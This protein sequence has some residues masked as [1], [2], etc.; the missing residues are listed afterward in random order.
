[1]D[2]ARGG[3]GPEEPEEDDVHLRRGDREPAVVALQRRLNELAKP[4]GLSLVRQDGFFGPNTE[5]SC[6]EIVFLLGLSE[7]DHPPDGI[8][9]GMRRLLDDPSARGEAQLARAERRQRFQ[10]RRLT[11]DDLIQGVQVLELIGGWDEWVYR[12]SE[13]V[14]FSAEDEKVFVRKSTVHFTLP[15]EMRSQPDAPF[16]VPLRLMGKWKL[17]R[18][19]VRDESNSSLALLS[20]AEHGPIGAAV[21]VAFAYQTYFGSPLPT[22]EQRRDVKVAA[23]IPAEVMDD[24]CA[25]ANEDPPR[26]FRIC[27]TLG[28]RGSATA[29]TPDQA[30]IVDT[31]R[32]TLATSDTFM[33]LAY[34]LARNYLLMVWCPPPFD[35]RRV[36][37]LSYD[38]PGEPP[39]RLTL[40]QRWRQA[41]T[42]IKEQLSTDVWPRPSGRPA[43][44]A[45]GHITISVASATPPLFETERAEGQPCAEVRIRSSSAAEGS[46][47]E[48]RP[49]TLHSNRV[50]AVSNLPVGDYELLFDALPGF[51]L[52]SD[53]RHTVAVSSGES[54]RVTVECRQMGA[55]VPSSAVAGPPAPAASLWRR[56]A[57]AFAW[58]SQA[59]AIR[60]RIGD[61]GSYHFEFEAPP[62]LQI[63]RSKLL[64]DQRSVLE[65]VIGSSQRTHLYVP[66]H[67]S[68][69]A[70]GWVQVNLRP[71]GESILR[72]AV[73]TGML[74]ALAIV[75]IALHWQ[76]T[77]QAGPSGIA[78][79]LAVPGGLS[80][81]VSQGTGSRVT[82]ARL[83]GLR[84]IALLPGLAGFVAAG[85]VLFGGGSGSWPLIAL[86]VVAGIA[87]L[88]GI[89]LIATAR[90]TARPREQRLTRRDQG[91]G[92]QPQQ[93][94]V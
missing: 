70:N 52:Q 3:A 23:A 50:R 7:R 87:V 17:P 12:R 2:E 65:R 64:D 55:A 51:H 41:S 94:T 75:G 30:R 10:G 62:G 33:E 84:V 78:L 16:A 53:R 6:K 83:F 36:I 11:A 9:N 80:A 63:T 21:L 14:R 43:P 79:L 66:S 67:R 22:A 42:A 76:I 59:V 40:R 91:P 27:A 46:A 47:S 89:L 39:R 86:W 38:Q 37:K 54:K 18:F 1:M 13:T 24:L 5:A 71:R 77:G 68:Q 34:E 74:A 60:V 61:G 32:R 15:E 8:T 25:I 31:W 28:S 45:V 57:I 49:L 73:L 26:A 85:L 44:V 29:L 72:S 92:Y 56:L 48:S 20:R 4:L 82:D 81:Y 90:L 88:I 19:H 69:P 93:L 58:R 35:R